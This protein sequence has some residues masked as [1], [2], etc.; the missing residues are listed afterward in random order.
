M[1]DHTTQNLAD[2]IDDFPIAMI[3]SVGDAGALVAQPFAMQ[4]QHHAFDGE[5]W[6]LISAEAS[7][8]GRVHADPRVNIALSARDS[9]VSIAGHAEVVEDRAKTETMWDASAEAWFPDGKD[10]AR[11][12]VLIVH[13]D[14]A[15]YWDTPGGLVA[16][17]LSFVKSK[18]TGEPLDIEHERVDL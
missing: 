11:I 14:S 17:A 3:T 6:F 9:W 13:A 8:V 18:A 4:Q 12:R 16:T 2:L 15:E 7:L 1:T 5:L 10:D